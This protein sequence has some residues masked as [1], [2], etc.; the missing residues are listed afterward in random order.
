MAPSIQ[1]CLFLHGALCLPLETDTGAPV[2]NTD[3]QGQR[4]RPPRWTPWVSVD[5]VMS[6]DGCDYQDLR[7]YLSLGT[8]AA[9]LNRVLESAGN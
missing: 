6:M 2:V 1:E 7:M 3:P 5:Y 9:Q 4:S 8:T